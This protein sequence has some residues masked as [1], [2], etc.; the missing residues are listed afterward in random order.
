VAAIVYPRRGLAMKLPILPRAVVSLL[1]VPWIV[2]AGAC[3]P[4]APP[5]SAPPAAPLVAPARRSGASSFPPGECEGI[6]RLIAGV[7]KGN[8]MANVRAT[9]PP[10]ELADITARVQR[11][12]TLL[13]FVERTL[14]SPVLAEQ[15]NHITRASRYLTSQTGALVAGVYAGAPDLVHLEH[16]ISMGDRSRE[17]A[18]RSAAA[19]CEEDPSRAQTAA[20][21]TTYS[22]VMQ[23]LG[24]RFQ[25]CYEDEKKR[26]RELPVGELLIAIYIDPPGRPTLVGPVDFSDESPYGADLVGCV[27]RVIEGATFPSPEGRALVHAPLA[28]Q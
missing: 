23:Q 19:R 22:D 7:R 6:L 16:A 20:W 25:A 12:T 18:M 1:V 24:P 21:T 14:T 4:I 27:V 26:S 5:P 9:M 17:I 28:P 2:G 3:A 8:P 13:Q 11:A 15:A 10:E